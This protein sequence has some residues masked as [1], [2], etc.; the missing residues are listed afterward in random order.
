M[1]NTAIPLDVLVEVIEMLESQTKL[2]FEEMYKLNEY[3]A[4]LIYFCEGEGSTKAKKLKS[5]T[6]K[7]QMTI[8]KLMACADKHYEL[9]AEIINY[10]NLLVV[11]SNSGLILTQIAKFGVQKKD[12][13]EIVQNITIKIF[14]ELPRFDAEKGAIGTFLGV[15][16][17][18]CITKHKAQGG[19]SSYYQTVNHKLRLILAELESEG[20]DT[21][22]IAQ[23]SARAKER[24]YNF[25]DST[26]KNA[27]LVSQSAVSADALGQLADRKMSPENAVISGEISDAFY[28][29]LDNLNRFERDIIMAESLYIESNRKSPNAKNLLEIL[30]KKYPEITLNR[31]K[32]FRNLAEIKIAEHF[33]FYYGEAWGE[34]NEIRLDNEGKDYASDFSDFFEEE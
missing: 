34:N 5:L 12:Y 27:M 6:K 7:S 30:Q 24:G 14:E 3:Y 17:K 18:E 32:Y 16:I 28:E 21:P 25:S 22:T 19:E 11:L 15:Y 9:D 10:I 4:S 2:K 13:T 23:L 29:S 26:I 20:Y 1:A 31:V 33:E 8:T